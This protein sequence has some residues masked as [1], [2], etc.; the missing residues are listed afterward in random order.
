MTA[1]VVFFHAHPDDEAL[2]TG[3]TMARLSAEGHRVVLVTATVGE[4]GL[5]SPN[6]IVGQ[7]LGAVRLRELTRS[8]DILGCARVVPLGYADS[9]MGDR[10]LRPDNAFSVV[11]PEVPARRLAAILDEER[12]QALVTYDGAGG[13]GHPDHVQVHRA[14]R[15]AGQMAGTPLELQA[16]VDRRALQRALRLLALLGLGSDELRPSQVDGLYSSRDDITHQVNVSKQMDQKRAAMAA[17]ASQ[18]TGDGS[19]RT[20]A[21]LLRLP[22]PVFRLA[23]GREWFVEAGRRPGVRPLDDVLAS[24]RRQGAGDR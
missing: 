3:G 6:W 11:P 23:L 19:R 20:L 4:G 13:Y 24:L 5:S 12:A 8:A 16:T 17:H 10:T 2:F 7:S 9:G 15:L 22:R 1:T 18:T 14:G 21:L